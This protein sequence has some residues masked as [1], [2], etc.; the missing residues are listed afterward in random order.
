MWRLLTTGT[1]GIVIGAAATWAVLGRGSGGDDPTLVPLPKPEPPTD[2]STASQAEVRPSLAD[3]AANG[4]DFERNTALYDLLAAT[5]AADVERLLAE[6]EDLTPAPHRHDIARVLYIRFAVTDPEAAVDHLMARTYR[7]SWV[8]AV[9]RAWAHADIDAAVARAGQLDGDA[10]L[11]ATR[12]IL[13]LELPD[14]QREAIAGQLE[15]RTILASIEADEDLRGHTDFTFAWQQALAVTDAPQ[16]LQRLGEVLK[17]WAKQDPVAAMNAALELAQQS[18]ND[19]AS[20]ALMLQGTVMQ[21]WAASDPD[22][23]IAWL[24]EQ[25]PSA[26]L[27]IM[28][29]IYMGALVRKS[30]DDA[31]SILDVAPEH[32]VGD[33][34]QGLIS[35]MR[36]P[37]V[38]IRDVDL[39]A[40][41]SWYSSL[42]PKDRESLAS[43]LSS[44]FVS[45]DAERALNWAISLDGKAKE[46]AVRSIIVQLGIQDPAKAKRLVAGIEDRETQL[47]AAKSL[48]FTQASSDPQAALD[49]ARSFA[50]ESVRLELVR[51][52][53]GQWSRTDP[54]EAV[55][56]VLRLRDEG[57][58]DQVAARIAV[59]LPREGRVDLAERLFDALRSG[60][61]RRTL[62]GIL[63]YHYTNTD[64]NP[65]KAKY[66]ESIL[67]EQD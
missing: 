22:A 7:S 52:V 32:L 66:Y 34:Q 25:K 24:A 2:L 58:R 3:I 40:L 60:E 1:L 27:R 33:A 50:D 37:G 41:L 53:F 55:R 56:E 44:V 26:S 5:S 17:V 36:T 39:D 13:E 63:H 21:T 10:K 65:Q 31:I 42:P 35:A 38:A 19:P 51:A 28:T 59:S 64:P 45:H 6:V 49:W 29:Y 54:D 16:R 43:T 12:A 48:V 23:A 11:L 9:F 67:T 61:S 8:R 47:D 18:R 20:P 46:E 57:L 62:A 4:D 14:W 15:G 30:L